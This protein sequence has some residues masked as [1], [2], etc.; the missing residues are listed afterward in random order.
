[1]RRPNIIGCLAWY[2]E[3]PRWL[4]EAVESFAGIASHV[5]AL[6]GAFA[7]WPN[8]QPRS[9][10]V[11]AEAIYAAA[12]LHGIGCTVHEP[13]APWQGNEVEKRSALFALAEA[14]AKPGDWL[15]VFDADELIKTVPSDLFAR[16]G[17]TPRDVGA[18]TLW[19]RNE[20][21]DHD[22][23]WEGDRRL[24]RAGHGLRVVGQHACYQTSD[25]RSLRGPH[26]EATEDLSDLVV[27]HRHEARQPERIDAKHEYYDVRD[28]LGVEQVPT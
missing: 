26:Q 11:Q 28:A 24:F 9:S 1:M 4:S 27:E 15:W 3:N 8:A 17:A 25:G 12:R 21:G 7:L 19:M 18:L 20:H 23:V 6:D 22:H 2:D 5:V 10:A 16:L 13:D 14:V